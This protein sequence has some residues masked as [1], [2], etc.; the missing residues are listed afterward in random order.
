MRRA[1]LLVLA[2]LPVAAWAQETGSSRPAVAESSY[3]IGAPPNVVRALATVLWPGVPF[4]ETEPDETNRWA[5]QVV[6]H[7]RGALVRLQRYVELREAMGDP[8]EPM[9]VLL[10]V[11]RSAPLSAATRRIQAKGASSC[12]ARFAQALHIESSPPE[13]IPNV[14]DGAEAMYER[15][16]YP[17]AAQAQ[18]I[19]GRVFV[20]FV[21]DERGVPNCPIVARGV[22]PLLDQAAVDAVSTLRFRPGRARG[23]SLEVKFSFP[24]TFRLPE[25]SAD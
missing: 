25:R 4:T 18:G 9:A 3:L 11:V 23:P 6:A 10:R 1:L 7:E 5:A 20:T 8:F 13:L 19:E 15:L 22:H 16:A 12:T 17:E 21:L 24:V 14:S 2:L